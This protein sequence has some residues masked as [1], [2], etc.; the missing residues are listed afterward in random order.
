ML[1]PPQHARR[2]RGAQA[3]RAL[4]EM[5]GSIIVIFAD[6]IHSEH[7]M[8]LAARLARRERAELFAVYIIEV[9]LVL[10]DTALTPEEDREALQ[11]LATAEAIA[12]KHGAQ[13]PTPRSSTRAG[14]APPRSTRAKTEGAH[15]LVLGS[16][17]EG[18]YTGAPLG[19]AIDEI[20]DAREC[21][22]LIGVPGQYGTLLA[23][24]AA[25]IAAPVIAGLERGRDKAASIALTSS[26]VRGRR[27]RDVSAPPDRSPRRRHRR[28]SRRT[29]AA[30][31][32]SRMI[33][34]GIAR[35]SPAPRQC[36]APGQVARTAAF[37]MTLSVGIGAS[38]QLSA[39]SGD[40]ADLCRAMQRDEAVRR[41]RPDRSERR[42]RRAV[43][44][45]AREPLAC[46]RSP[47]RPAIRRTLLRE[48][49]YASIA[50]NDAAATERFGD[51]RAGDG[52]RR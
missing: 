31:P 21:D 38:E 8:V 18:K 44:N 17:R 7:M 32:R 48:R 24:E 2:R 34:H 52:R 35:R 47:S 6:E 49:Y 19:R 42:D 22:V 26:R 25:T 12:R 27:R 46:A 16:Y 4:R 37:A 29:T 30:R 43:A 50:V 23:E 1:H 11:V 13:Y 15:L 20:A 45:R 28:R 39:H 14:S 40:P 10:P 51:R 33:R 36:E 41:E 9:P 3:D 5:V